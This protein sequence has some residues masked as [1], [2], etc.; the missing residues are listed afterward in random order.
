M[1][2]K[3]YQLHHQHHQSFAQNFRENQG[4]GYGSFQNHTQVCYQLNQRLVPMVDETAQPLSL[5]YQSAEERH[6]ND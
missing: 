3:S 5:V 2:N 4:P 1:A 6:H